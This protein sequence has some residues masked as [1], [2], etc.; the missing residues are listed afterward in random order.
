MITI[1]GSFG[2]GG[3]QILRSSL[4]LALVTGEAVR[5]ENIRAGREKP[6]LR[7]QHLTAVNAAVAVGAAEVQGN[8]KGSQELY[9][10]PKTVKAGEYHFSVGTAGSTTLVLQTVLPALMQADEKSVL[11]I[12]GGTHNPMAPPF[13]FLAG[14]FL[15]ITERMGWKVRAEL[16]RPGFFPAGGGQI[17]VFIELADKL[18]QIEI[19]ERGLIVGQRAKALV[20]RLPRHIGERELKVIREVLKWDRRWLKVEEVRDSAG[21]GNVLTA[22][23]EYENVTEVFS[24]FGEKG[25]PAEKVAES[26]AVQVSNYLGTEAPVGK[27]L[28]DQLMIPMALAGGGRYRTAVLTEHSRTNIEV[29]MKFLEVDIVVGQINEAVWDIEIQTA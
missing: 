16:E 27:Y 8:K 26:V 20:A 23:I 17:K 24:G 21:P 3:G 9:F 22:E 13:D 12:E 6:G 7:R 29:I 19:I 1:D 15:P 25:W 4:G 11:T 5:L 28:A 2:E 14:A 18:N 10:A